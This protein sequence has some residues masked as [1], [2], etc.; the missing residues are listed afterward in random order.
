MTVEVMQVFSKSKHPNAETLYVY[1]MYDKNEELFTI[2]ANSENIYELDDLVKVAKVGSVLKENNLHIEESNIR[3]IISVGM[4]IGKSDQPRGTDLTEEYCQ[5]TYHVPWTSIEALYNVRKNMIDSNLSQG[6]E[7]HLREVLYVGKI[8]LDGTCAA[9][10]IHPDKELI[11]Q[12]RSKII[13]PEDDNAGFARWVKNNED[14]FN[15]L[16]QN[17]PF[18]VFGEWCGQGIQKRCS[19]SKI[20]RKVFCV[21]AIQYGDEF[22]FGPESIAKSLISSVINNDIFVLPF[23]DHI[24]IDYDNTE[25]LQ[26]SIDVI[27]GWVA[28]VEKCDPYVQKT[29]GIEGLGEGIVFYPVEKSSVLDSYRISRRSYTELV[30]K[31]KGEEHKVVKTKQSVQIDPEVAKSIDEFVELF[32]TQNR[33]DQIAQKVGPFETKLTGLFLKEFTADVLKESTAELAASSMQWKDVQGAV[34]M[35]A[36]EWWL[37]QTKVL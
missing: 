26:K 2:V 7:H 1:G 11:C 22:D 23:M 27:N 35:A 30:F 5:S 21:F 8:K 14:Y 20:D 13:T 29:F 3:G 31:A 17:T 12:S 24:E 6:L 18:I 9:V 33:L 10:Q 34:S 32:V 37:A 25:K 28:E 19:I 15:S 36:R 16:K 4:A